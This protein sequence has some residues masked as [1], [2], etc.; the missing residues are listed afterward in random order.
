M[1]PAPSLFAGREKIISGIGS[2]L[3]FYVLALLI[4]EA[5]LFGAG[6]LFNLP[7]ETRT[8]LVWA[9]LAVF[10]FIVLVVLLLVIRYPQ[11]LVFTERSHLQMALWGAKSNPVLID[12]IQHAHPTQSPTTAT[13]QLAASPEKPLAEPPEESS[14]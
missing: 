10:L 8:Y 5:F 1:T 13:N 14:K 4:V 11:N 6:S 9:G 2:P 3:G 12:A 7:V